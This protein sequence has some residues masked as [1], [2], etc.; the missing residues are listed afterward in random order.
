[1]LR[2]T[3][4]FL[5]YTY[6]LP[7]VLL[8]FQ[9]VN[10]LAPTTPYWFEPFLYEWDRTL[11]GE[12]P[13]IALSSWVN[14]PLSELMHALYFTYYLILIG[15]LLV[16]WYGQGENKLAAR[17]K[18]ISGNVPPGPAFSSMITGM[19]F[20]FLLSFIHFPFLPA[21][22]PWENPELMF[23]LPP[24]EGFLFKP[25]VDFIIERGAVPGGCFPSS[26]VAG[27]WGIVM[28]L[29]NMHR[30]AAVWLGIATLG[31][32]GACVYTRYHHGVDVVA[33]LLVGL[34][35]GWMGRMISERLDCS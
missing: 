7:I 22:G 33:G 4:C 23:P 9:E 21:R 2:R 11:F 28:G 26:H 10:G 14:K 13:A 15:G 34:F 12:L 30:R 24:L 19:T 3:S 31:M 17:A 32:S 8:F 16:A 25:L 6:P 20:A 35:G 29:T 1:M 5:R 27:S 18:G